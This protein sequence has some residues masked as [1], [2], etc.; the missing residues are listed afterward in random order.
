M[1]E[2]ATGS[3]RYA[4]FP[5]EKPYMD[6]RMTGLT[7]GDNQHCHNTLQ[8]AGVVVAP[9]PSPGFRPSAV[10]ALKVILQPLNQNRMTGNTQ[11]PVSVT[12]I[13]TIILPGSYVRYTIVG[14]NSSALREAR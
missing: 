13:M 5:S 2:M 8:V 12:D 9:D 1:Q 4:V 7:P 6:R 11:S 3:D 10:H 14:N